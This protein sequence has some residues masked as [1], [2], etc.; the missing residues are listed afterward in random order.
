MENLARTVT[1]LWV[2]LVCCLALVVTACMPITAVPTPAA[3]ATPVQPTPA[4]TPVD[5]NDVDDN[6]VDAATEEAGMV[7]RQALMTQAMIDFDEVEVIAVEPMEW[8]DACLGLAGP[9][10]FCAQVITPGYEVT[11]KVEGQEYVFRTDEDLNII[12]PD[13]TDLAYSPLALEEC[14]MLRAEVEELLGTSVVLSQ[15][16]APF[17]ALGNEQVGFSCRLHSGGTG[18][19]FTNFVEVATNLAALLE[20]QGWTQD[21]QYVADSPTATVLGLRRVNDLAVV[22]VGW[23]PAPGVECPED[24]PISVC[25][26]ELEPAQMIYTVVIDLVQA[27]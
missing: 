24:Q 22:Q 26:E 12:R 23:E 7:V 1:H 13:V 19:D 14:E 20:E 27:T 5:D 17:R 16:P 18:E 2:P 11:L 21:M 6:D 8:P 9:D 3:D 25:A 10:E 4:E 15:L